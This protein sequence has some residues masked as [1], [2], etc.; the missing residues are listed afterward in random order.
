M[1]STTKLRRNKMILD[2]QHTPLIDICWPYSASALWVLPSGCVRGSK[3]GDTPC[4]NSCCG[5]LSLPHT[6]TA[7][8]VILMPTCTGHFLVAASAAGSGPWHQH[9]GGATR[10]ANTR[11]PTL[12]LCARNGLH[13]LFCFSKSGQSWLQ[14][15]GVRAAALPGEERGVSACLQGPGVPTAYGGPGAPLAFTMVLQRRRPPCAGL[16]QSQP[17]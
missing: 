10:A 9:T 7:G 2:Q 1:Q 14:S 5:P 17:C 13:F 3:A 4:W 16:A 11:N 15:E 6:G 12:K 8:E